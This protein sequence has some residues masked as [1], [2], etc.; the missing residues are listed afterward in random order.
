MQALGDLIIAWR[1]YQRWAERAIWDLGLE[2]EDVDD[3][4]SSLPFFEWL[5]DLVAEE[6]EAGEAC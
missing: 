2:G 6:Q 3:F 1:A 4:C 5:D